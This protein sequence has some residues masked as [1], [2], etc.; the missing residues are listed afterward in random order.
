MGGKYA[1]LL[2]QTE[3]AQRAAC[4]EHGIEYMDTIPVMGDANGEFRAYM[5][6]ANGKTVRL[7]RKDKEHLS[8]EGN[9][10]VLNMLL[11]RIEKRIAAFRN[12]NPDKVLS[13]KET[14]RPVQAR[15]DVAFKYVP[16]K[17]KRK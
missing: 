11:P 3:I 4:E 15:M 7:R 12:D 17:R 1:K 2:K 10:V 9:M 16:K 13:E 14:S 6:D 8:P 5:T